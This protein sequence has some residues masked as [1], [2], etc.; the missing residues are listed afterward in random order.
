MRS[1]PGARGLI[2]TVDHLRPALGA[3]ALT[4]TALLSMLPFCLLYLLWRLPRRLPATFAFG[5]EVTLCILAA[6][7]VTSPWLVR[8]YSVFGKFVFVRDN[9]PARNA[10]GEQRSVHRPVDTK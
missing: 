9:L 10:H 5:S 6:A 7:L 3:I 1:L 2:W 8:N 4:N